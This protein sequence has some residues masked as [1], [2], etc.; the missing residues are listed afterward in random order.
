MGQKAATLDQDRTEEKIR[1]RLKELRERAEKSPI[2]T[3]DME[4][5]MKI[6]QDDIDCLNKKSVDVTKLSNLQ[7]EVADFMM[8]KKNH[9]LKIMAGV[10]V[11]TSVGV[12]VAV[13]TPL[14]ILPAIGFTSSGVAAGSTAA[15]IQSSV[16][17]AYT[18]TFFGGFMSA[19]AT[20]TIA[21]TT[22]AGIAGT[23]A[24]VGGIVGGNV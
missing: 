8:Q 2:I 7:K 13:A 3:I 24:A 15:L 9:A 4:Q 5:D 16:Y 14:L 17:G 11:G 10:L 6:I 18:S 23:G 12:A 22:T 21:A 20:G 1:I 19:G